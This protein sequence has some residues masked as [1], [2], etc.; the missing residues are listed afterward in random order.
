MCHDSRDCADDKDCQA[1]ASSQGDGTVFHLTGVLHCD[2]RCSRNRSTLQV[3][4]LLLYGGSPVS[5]SVLAARDGV[6]ADEIAAVSASWSD[7][8][9]TA[10]P[11]QQGASLARTA[12]VQFC[13]SLAH[14]GQPEGDAAGALLLNHVL[15]ASQDHP[16]IQAVVPF[17][18]STVHR[19][20]VRLW[21]ALAV[22]APF[23]KAANSALTL[24]GL[25]ATLQQGEIA[26]V[27]QYQ[28]AG[29]LFGHCLVDCLSLI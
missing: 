1:P 25:L 7:A 12:A 4:T 21:Q 5:A 9:G 29:M 8:T 19:K 23:H 14:L 24:E 15:A 28:E 10:M 18:G 17:K 13:S 11:V 22:L 27:K 20:K 2:L 3:V 16:D 6:L 26:S